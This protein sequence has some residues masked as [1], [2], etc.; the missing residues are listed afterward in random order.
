MINTTYDLSTDAVK[1]VTPAVIKLGADVPVRVTFSEAPGELSSLQ[2]AL[3]TDASS[4]TVLAFTEDFSEEGDNVWT[5]LLDASDTRLATFMTSK[6]PTA[7]QAEL[8]AVIDGVRRVSPNFQVTVQPAIITGPETSDEGPTY[9]TEAQSDA[10][11]L[12]EDQDGGLHKFGL[13]VIGEGATSVTVAFDTPMVGSTMVPLPAVCKQLT[14]DDNI[15]VVA[16]FDVSNLGFT[17]VLN[18]ATPNGNYVLHWQ[19]FRLNS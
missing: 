8:V 17:A 5:A 11:Y 4:P 2:L 6:G 16:L 10:R 13:E 19:A 9:L 14:G 3:G 12:S 15:F 7:V 1:L 18:G